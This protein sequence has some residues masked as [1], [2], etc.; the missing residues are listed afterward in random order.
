MILAMHFRYYPVQMPVLIASL[1]R[2][3]ARQSRIAKAD[4]LTLSLSKAHSKA[5]RTAHLRIY[6]S[7]IKITPVLRIPSTFRPAGGASTIVDRDHVC[8]SWSTLRTLL[9][10][11]PHV[12][13]RRSPAIPAYDLCTKFA[14]NP[15]TNIIGYEIPTPLTR[16]QEK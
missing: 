13:R 7:R 15:L 1:L 3:A 6:D 4:L 14:V 10:R 12:H 16:S 8:P 9:I 11:A 2:E 5:H